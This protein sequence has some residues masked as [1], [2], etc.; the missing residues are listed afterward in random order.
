LASADLGIPR[1]EDL[2]LECGQ[3]VLVRVDLNV[4]LEDGAVADDLRI[5]TALPTLAWLREHD[6]A[7]VVA[8]H[9]GRP[10]G[11]PDQK[12]S[13]APVARRLG[14]LLGV[15]IPVTQRV[16]GAAVEPYVASL[17]PGDVVMLEN[18]RFDPGETADDPA[19]ATNLCELAD[20]YV[21]EAFGASHRAHASIVGPPRL[22]P[23][24][25]GRLLFTEVET[26]S[27]LV[28]GDAHPFV[29]VLGGAKV[30]D[31]LGVIDALLRRC[32]AILV[33]GAMMFTFLRARG[34]S[35]GESLVEPEMVDECHRLLETGR[36]RIPTDVVVADDITH[37]AEARV[38]SADAMPSG[39]K[40]LDIGPE[41][42]AAFA[43]E[44][45][46]AAL[47]LWNGPMGVFEVAAFAAGTRAVAEAV[48]A[49]PGFTVVGGGD[50][51]AAVRRLGLADR[52]DHVSTGGGAS[53]EFIERGDL[54]GLQ[55]LR[56]GKRS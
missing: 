35:V 24:A 54:P 21:N 34:H 26:L 23:S 37:D 4:P 12:Y 18:L 47:L 32:D 22:L 27:R 6:A 45:G 55:A 56:E 50:S 2:P 51:A 29:A 5:T 25:G 36:V 52:I 1:L 11:G 49:C 39:L 8:G 43:T 38:V 14:Q 9:L 3:R 13:M 16:V 33:G 53:L 46:G 10:K 28:V 44:V 31:K 7:V 48:A 41:T 30:S 19:F 15:E 20:A 40:G 17:E 42:A